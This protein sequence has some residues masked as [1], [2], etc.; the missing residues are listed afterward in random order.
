[1]G[2]RIHHLLCSG[3]DFVVPRNA[4]SLRLDYREDKQPNV[5][6]E[7]PSFVDQLLHV[8]A[9]MLDLLE[10]AAYVY[11]ADR[12]SHRGGKSAVEYHAWSRDFFFH[13]KVRDFNFWS[14]ID[15]REKLNAALSFLSGDRRFEFDFQ[16]GHETPPT[17]L[18]DLQ[19]VSVTDLSKSRIALF[20]G[21]L[22]SLAGAYDIL[23]RTSDHVCLVSHRSSQPQVGR[24]QDQL[25]YSLQSRFPGRVQHYKFH[26]NLTG[27]RA[28]E[29]TQRTR[30]FLYSA[31]ATAIAATVGVK[32]I[33][34]FE[35]GVTSFNFPRRQDLVNARATRTTHPKT[36]SLL[37]D[38]FAAI[39]STKFQ[40]ETPFIWKTKGDV[41]GALVAANGSALTPSAISC[42]RTFLSMGGASHCGEC[43]Q[44]IDRRFAS[45]AA[46]MDE[47]DDSVPYAVN[48]IDS[49]IST[50]E[51]RTTLVDYVRQAHEFATWNVDH[52]ATQL[53]GSIS[54]I[55]DYVGAATEEE[56]FDR[57]AELC[58]RHGKQVMNAIAKIR[59]KHDRLEEKI[60][61]GSLLSLIAQREYLK[62]PVLRLVEAVRDRLSI[63]IP[64]AFQNNPPKDEPDLNDKI[65]AILNTDRDKFL[66]EHPAVRFGLA[67]AI[68]DHSAAEDDLVIETKYLRGST[69][70]SRASDGM[71][72]DLIKYPPAAHILFIVYDPERA[73]SDD[74]TFRNA[75]EEKGRCT[76][77][78]VR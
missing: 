49:R 29:E 76:V 61:K 9:R 56:A 45:Y 30:M 31:I 53:F 48:V 40:I 75:L 68:P 3:A 33:T 46:R 14:R 78:L 6:I 50:D 5:R 24:T 42:S 8:P 10:I 47:L 70:P 20:S 71:A 36:I 66:R 57:V 44:C 11:C 18:F 69:T 15:V 2:K 55:V 63:A 22:D 60:T 32:Q 51:A 52:F 25:V 41:I 7:L 54:E 1:M 4:K 62:P 37:R 23:T 64:L 16:A 67:T 35:N 65:S 26:C 72:A 58:R 13:I 34:I 73:V 17:S 27:Q 74:Q 39:V 21:G 12:W 59:E 38:I 19:Q 43:S 28:A 77:H